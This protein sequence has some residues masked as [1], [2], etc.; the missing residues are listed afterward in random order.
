MKN[1]V[2]Y[3]LRNF[4]WISCALTIVLSGLGLLFVFSS[5]YTPA[6]PISFFFKKQ[7]L[8][9]LVG[10]GL[11]ALAAIAPVSFITQWGSWG[12]VATLGLLCYTS[13]L[14]KVA[15]GGKR[16]ISLYFFKFQPSELIKLT[17]PISIGSYFGESPVNTHPFSSLVSFY[18]YLAP[19]LAIGTS[20]IL[21]A[22]QPDLGS[23]LIV[24][25]MG[26]TLLWI[27]NISS[28][29]FVT[30]ALL[31]VMGAPVLWQNLRPYQKERVMVLLG[32]GEKQKA[33]YQ[34]E[35]ATIAIGSGRL[36]GKGFM[37]GTQN[38]LSFLPEDHT[39]F[40]FAVICEEWGFLG[41]CLVILLFI[42]LF[43]RLL[44]AVIFMTNRFSQT[45]IFG[46][47]IHIILSTSINIGMVIGL[48]PIVGIPLPLF[49]YGITHTWVTL[50]SLGLANNINLRAN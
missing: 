36:T 50:M 30:M 27:C 46:L 20:F 21:I 40:I 42:A 37:R 2:N 17:L 23:G 5:T 29:F 32:N 16:W 13:L 31:L 3:F 18:H 34:I 28:T 47:V 41:A 1:N 43:I 9:Y 35:Q 19:L 4:D 49:S 24:L 7:A 8:G 33:R 38:K 14:G 11:Y 12:F 26:L 15:L 25:F 39:D 45:I 44:G 48:L 6:Q 10:F 22:R